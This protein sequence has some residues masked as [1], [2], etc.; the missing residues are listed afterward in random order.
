MYLTGC[1]GRC[2]ADAWNRTRRNSRSLG[3]WTGLCIWRWLPDGRR[4]RPV[5]ILAWAVCVRGKLAH[6][7]HGC[8]RWVSSGNKC[9]LCW[10]CF[11]FRDFDT[12]VAS[13]LKNSIKLGLYC[14]FYKNPTLSVFKISL[15][16]M[17]FGCLDLRVVT[18]DNIPVKQNV[19]VYVS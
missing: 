7:R 15:G 17:T 18:V 13:R 16:I 12:K 3:R 2:S 4:D 14:L 5:C 11:Y 19:V 10:R 9:G 1:I 8:H 6:W